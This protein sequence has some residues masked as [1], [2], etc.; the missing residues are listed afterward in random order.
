[1]LFFSIVKAFILMDNRTNKFLG[2]EGNSV[3]LI[4]KR[5][6]A[7][8]FSLQPTSTKGVGVILSIGTKALGY[9]RKTDIIS[10]ME[11]END[12]KNLHFRLALTADGSYMIQFEDRCVGHKQNKTLGLTDCSNDSDA[13]RLNKGDVIRGI[14]TQESKIKGEL[15]DLKNKNM[16]DS[17]IALPEKTGMKLSVET[18][19]PSFVSFGSRDTGIPTHLF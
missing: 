7:L 4:E 12:D 16:Q 2:Q 18:P 17:D 11:F 13:L 19:K 14:V 10:I 5:D 3:K 9:N 15:D 6:N 8:D 1:M